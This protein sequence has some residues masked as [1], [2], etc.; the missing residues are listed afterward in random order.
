M[1]YLKRLL[2]L[3]TLIPRL[4]IAFVCVCVLFPF[5]ITIIPAIYYIATGRSYIDDF[6]PLG[7]ALGLWIIGLGFKWKD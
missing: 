3:L 7:M 6:S 2:L 4:I 5:D 1:I